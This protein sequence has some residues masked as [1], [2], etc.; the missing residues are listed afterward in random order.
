MGI[1]PDATI[2]WQWGFVKLN[3][4]ILFTWILMASWVG[5]SWWVGRRLRTGVRG[6]P[7]GRVQ[8]FL[9]ITVDTMRDQ[10]REAA[11]EDPD[12]YLAFVGT[13]FL[14]VAGAA[15][16]SL[17]PGYVPPTASLSTTAALA[18]CVF[19]AVPAFGILRRGVSQYLRD[20]VRPTPL[21][22]PFH[23]VGELSRTLALAVRLFGNMMSGQLVAAIVV[24][25]VPLFFPVILKGFGL[26]IGVIQAYVFATLALVYIL[27]AVRSHRPGGPEAGEDRTASGEAAG[28]PMPSSPEPRT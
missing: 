16:L 20:Y 23:L 24:S 14:F 15:L 26:L 2:Y 13:I 22:L 5:V 10:I 8:L 11:G 28:E 25:L 21:M 3:A 19:V 12:V 4:T 1:G 7:P 17:A 6:R 9:E 27:S 18:A